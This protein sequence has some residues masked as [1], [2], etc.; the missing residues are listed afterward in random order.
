MK[1]KGEMELL[2][3][4]GYKEIFNNFFQNDKGEVEDYEKGCKYSGD[5]SNGKKRRLRKIRIYYSRIY[6]G[7]FKEGKIK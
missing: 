7:E 6:E 4:S 3:K 2:N 5:I 1:G